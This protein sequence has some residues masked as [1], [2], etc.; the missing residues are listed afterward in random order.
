ME[1]E[2]L[3]NVLL[4]KQQI[5]LQVQQPLEK[6]Q[7]ETPYIEVTEWLRCTQTKNVQNQTL[8]FK[9][10][11]KA[12]G[13]RTTCLHLTSA[14]LQRLITSCSSVWKVDFWGVLTND[15]LSTH[16]RTRWEQTQTHQKSKLLST[17]TE[18]KEF[19]K[20]SWS[21]DPRKKV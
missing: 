3:Q 6:I 13:L 7:I 21:K 11:S 1:F 18:F 8:R 10:I 19:N 16:L 2:V 14:S 5:Q 4:A 15:Q 17:L 12:A 20:S 9:S